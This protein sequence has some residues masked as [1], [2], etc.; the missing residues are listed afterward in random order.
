[1]ECVLMALRTQRP[2]STT[3]E[4]TGLAQ[5]IAETRPGIERLTVDQFHRMIDSGILREGEPIELIDGILVRKDSSDIGGD[6][7]IHGPKHALCVQ[8]LKELDVQA[9]LH[10]YHLR[11][12]LPLVL[13]DNREPEPDVAIV[14]GTV[15][16]YQDHHPTAQD[17]LLA[18]EVSD[19]SLEYDRTVKGPVYAAAGI[20]VYW[21][22]NIRE[23]QI[24]VYRSP[25]L[26]EKRYSL[27]TDFR[28]G[29]TATLEFGPD[30]SV[31]V[32]VY[33]ILP[34]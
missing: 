23:R 29:D 7:M 31:G 12:Q 3:M 28:P 10:G 2:W 1:M 17:C 34:S 20:P 21:I 26:T 15:E 24:E 14:R 32:P 27:R 22:V 30:I 19:S 5:A 33:D 9:R 6:P 18:I 8:R 11:Q 16:H 25:I 13:S 4:S